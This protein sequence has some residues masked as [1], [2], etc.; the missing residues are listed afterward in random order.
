MNSNK[1][2]TQVV[3][4]DVHR[5][6][7]IQIKVDTLEQKLN[8]LNPRI[9]STNRVVDTVKKKIFSNDTKIQNIQQ[10][11]KSQDSVI[12]SY[13]PTQLQKYFSDY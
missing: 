8:R 4:T 2:S 11:A 10:T 1:S 9:D 12:R 3:S 7:S 5:I 6:D 13:N